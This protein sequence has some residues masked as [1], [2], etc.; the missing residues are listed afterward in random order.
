MIMD[1]KTCLKKLRLIASVSAATVDD[2]GNPQVRTI[3]V[4][5]TDDNGLYFLTARG[6]AFYHELIAKRHVQILGLS[7]FKEMIRLDGEALRIAD[8]QQKEWLDTLFA[9]NPYMGNVY[10]GA[11]RSILEVFSVTKGTI[12]YFNLGV[13]PIFRESYQFGDAKIREKGYFITDSCVECGICAQSCPQEC[14]ETGHPYRIEREHCLHC[15]QCHER[16]P[17]K[18]IRR[19]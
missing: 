16:C 18:A 8:D 14:I 5:H 19:L 4:M 7:R 15:G 3:G 13:H 1:A 12:E 6:K 11:S 2:E 10:P 17:N 9:K